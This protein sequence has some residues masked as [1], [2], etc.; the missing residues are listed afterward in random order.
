MSISERT[1]N[2]LRDVGLTGYESIAY[3]HLLTTGPSTA[4]QISNSTGLPYS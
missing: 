3:L 1:K 4:N 2:A